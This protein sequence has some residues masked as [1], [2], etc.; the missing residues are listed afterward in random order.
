MTRRKAMHRFLRKTG[1]LSALALTGMTLSGCVLQAASAVPTIMQAAAAARGARQPAPDLPLPPSPPAGQ[2][3]LYG[4]AEGTVA[5]RQTYDVLTRFALA[6]AADRPAQSV[7]LSDGPGIDAGFVPCDDKPLAV[8]FDADETLIWNLGAMRWFAENDRE[9][10]PAIWSEWERTGAG[11]AAAMPGAVE[12][13]QKLRAAGI[14]IVA[15][16]NRRADTAAG[17]VATLRAAGLGDF[18]HGRTLFLSGDDDSGS[19]KDGRRATIAAQYCVIAM[20]GDQ[21][22][23]FS[24][25]FNAPSLSL[26]E[27][28]LIATRPP[29]DQLWGAGW[30]LFAN[31][32]YGPSIRGD[33][34]DIYPAESRWAPDADAP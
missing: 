32:L 13:L 11:K 2:Q 26:R 3:W 24:D 15:N 22:G 25:V 31:P 9:F 33:F 18:E 12:A 14:T 34:D 1:A 4:S 7:V 27:R 17:T 16:T 20:A 10:D 21:L 8:L 30:F 5:T 28:K 23:D 19:K 29:V 6:R